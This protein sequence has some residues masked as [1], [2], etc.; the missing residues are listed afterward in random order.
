M[1]GWQMLVRWQ[2]PV[3]Q[4]AM[5]F[6]H[7]FPP[8]RPLGHS[9]ARQDKA[10]FSC[11]SPSDYSDY[12]FPSPLTASYPFLFYLSV[13]CSVLLCFTRCLFTPLNA[14]WSFS[15]FVCIIFNFVGKIHTAF[16]PPG[17]TFKKLRVSGTVSHGVWSATKL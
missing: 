9:Y 1:V 2:E 4:W 6:L 17:L 5:R 8:I 12:F 11:F 3:G 16:K 15:Q 13:V 14:F 10:R 7:E